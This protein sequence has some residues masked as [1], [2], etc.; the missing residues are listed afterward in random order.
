MI[1]IEKLIAKK[2]I[3]KANKNKANLFLLYFLLFI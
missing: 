1:L 3:K 2:I